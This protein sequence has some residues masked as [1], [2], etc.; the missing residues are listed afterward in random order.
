MENLKGLGLFRILSY[1]MV[2]LLSVLSFVYSYAYVQLVETERRVERMYEFAGDDYSKAYHLMDVDRAL[3]LLDSLYPR[4]ALV[5]PDVISKGVLAKAGYGESC[6]VLE[7]ID[8]FDDLDVNRFHGTSDCCDV[9]FVGVNPIVVDQ[10][11]DRYLIMCGGGYSSYIVGI[12]KPSLE[13]IFE[14]VFSVEGFDG[15]L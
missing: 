12:S 5:S 7:Y 15:G 3:P 10:K 13:V 6:D 1:L 4:G 9:S 14:R 8:L 2:C 11:N